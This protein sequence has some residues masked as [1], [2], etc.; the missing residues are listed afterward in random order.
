MSYYHQPMESPGGRRGRSRTPHGQ[1]KR[2]SSV[3]TIRASAET[4]R[5]AQHLRQYDTGSG[6]RHMTTFKHGAGPG[7]S[8]SPASDSW[9][10][11][12]LPIPQGFS[13]FPDVT[14]ENKM[15]KGEIERLKRGQERLREQNEELVKTKI[16]MRTALRNFHGEIGELRSRNRSLENKIK[17]MRLEITDTSQ[18]SASSIF[19]R[20]RG[21]RLGNSPV[22]RDTEVSALR[23]EATEYKKRNQELAT[24]NRN[25]VRKIGEQAK[26]IQKQRTEFARE[27]DDLTSKAFA[28]CA[29]LSDTEIQAKWKTLGFSI[30]QF[31]SEYFSEPLCG[32]AAQLLAQQ[33]EFSWLPEPAVTLQ[34]PMLYQVALESWIWHLLCFRIF[35]SHS[36]FWAGEVGQAF[37]VQCDQFRD[38]LANIHPPASR[39]A[40]AEKF[41]D[42]R[43]R[44]ADVITMFTTT[45]EASSAALLVQEMLEAL[46]LV[47]PSSYRMGDYVAPGLQQDL[48]GIIRNAADL[49]GIFRASK[50]DFQVFITR[51]KLPLVTPPGFGFPF[52]AETMELVKD[53]PRVPTNGFSPVVDLA[54]SPGILKSGNADGVNYGS[55]RVLVKLQTV[56]NLRPIL[57]FFHG[58]GMEQQ[59][60]GGE[61]GASFWAEDG[62]QCAIKKEQ[63]VETI[64]GDVVVVKEELQG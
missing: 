58:D 37:T 30:R 23:E 63:A 43:I 27:L 29:R 8:M 25:M 9:D 45:D 21:T 57:D 59:V 51:I 31:V 12:N 54:V 20:F 22:F 46:S 28:K 42:W 16:S 4:Q 17:E 50:A 1:K 62:C 15:L 41:H 55:D 19:A 18:G 26:Q 32:H 35:D 36:F 48:H 6:T 56:C 5:S 11:G 60:H 40:V 3:E 39:D 47:I 49:A 61:Q 38:A 33:T 53:I 34:T 64:I 7:S 24:E 14:Y 13:Q 2:Y 44:S 52:D 10:D